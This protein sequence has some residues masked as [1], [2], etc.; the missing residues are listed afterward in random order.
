MRSVGR[1][2]RV[3][4]IR[5]LGIPSYVGTGTGTGSGSGTGAVPGS[6]A[7]SIVAERPL[8]RTGPTRRE[9]QWSQRALLGPRN[10]PSMWPGCGGWQVLR[11]HAPRAVR[12]ADHLRRAPLGLGTAPTS[13]RPRS[14]GVDAARSR[15]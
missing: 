6:L 13:Q 11:L 12:W 9:R 7:Q 2:D 3:G 1:N 14:V 5:R 8:L 10:D 4:R 15:R